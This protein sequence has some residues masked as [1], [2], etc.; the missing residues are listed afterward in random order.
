MPPA[1]RQ[2]AGLPS[3]PTSEDPVITPFATTQAQGSRTCGPSQSVR[4]N[5]T[6][7]APGRLY[8]ARY[9]NGRWIDVGSTGVFEFGHAHNFAARTVTWKV[10]ASGAGI[11]S[12]SDSCV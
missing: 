9:T 4:V 10:I 12:V 8:Y 7:D 11:Q 3:A 1:Q 5:V 6:L 2:H